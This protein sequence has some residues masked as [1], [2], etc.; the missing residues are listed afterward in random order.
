MELSFCSTKTKL[1]YKCFLV[2]WLSLLVKPDFSKY[3]FKRIRFSKKARSSYIFLPFYHPGL[4][5]PLLFLVVRNQ[6]VL[7]L[8]VMVQHHFVVFTS[9]P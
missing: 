8:A 2:N 4:E 7:G 1:L 6:H 9:K 3:C 5:K